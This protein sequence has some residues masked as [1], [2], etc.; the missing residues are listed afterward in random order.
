MSKLLIRSQSAQRFTQSSQPC[1]PCASWRSLRPFLS[2][3]NYFN[4][5][6]LFLHLS[7]LQTPVMQEVLSKKL[8][9]YIIE[10]NPEL[11]LTLQQE[12]KLKDYLEQNLASVDPLLN[13]LLNEN[14]PVYLIEE[15]CLNEMTQSLRPSRFQYI[16]Q[17]LEEVRLGSS[18]ENGQL[19]GQLSQ[20][21]IL[22]YE[23]INL[24]TI[25]DPLF[26]AFQFSIN[27]EDDPHLKYTIKKTIEEYIDVNQASSQLR[28]PR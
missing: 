8:H 25:C 24:I 15:L 12:N 3:L 16:R 20:H 27:N 13:Q 17:I 5:L 2:Y 18:E 6:C 9:A 19:Y 21:R 10:N 7:S 11:L 28:S 23:I 4:S 14:K 22:N 1:V 26:D